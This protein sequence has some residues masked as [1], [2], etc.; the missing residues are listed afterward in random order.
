M[1][2]EVGGLRRSR[3]RVCGFAYGSIGVEG[4]G[5]A[6]LRAPLRALVLPGAIAYPLF[7]EEIARSSV[8]KVCEDTEVGLNNTA[9]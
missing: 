2:A 7:Y 5:L 3:Y 6:P 8:D 1:R 4:T 9:P